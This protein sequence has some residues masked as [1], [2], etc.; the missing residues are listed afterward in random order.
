MACPAGRKHV[1][2]WSGYTLFVLAVLTVVLDPAHWANIV[3]GLLLAL[4][5]AAL[6]VHGHR[7]QAPVMEFDTEEF[8]YTLGHYSVSVVLEEIGSYHVLPGRTRSLGLRDNTGRPMRFPSLHNRR[9]ARSYLP[10]TGMT[11]P[12]RVEMFMAA[13]GIPPRDRSLTQH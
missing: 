11:D 1:E 8:R 2:L 10:L 4:L 6:I 13:A 7:I 5:G 9:T 3:L 12:G